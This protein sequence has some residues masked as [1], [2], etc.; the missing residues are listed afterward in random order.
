M[1][2]I[3]GRSLK[4]RIADGPLPLDEALSTARQIGDALSAAHAKGIIHRDIKPANIMLTAEGRPML[5][6]F[7]L[8]KVS[9]ATKLTRTGTTMGRWRTCRPSRCRGERPDHRS[10]IWALGV[11]LYE[12]VSGR[13]PFGGDYEAAMLYSILMRIPSHSREKVVTYL[14]ALTES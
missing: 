3:E 8:A 14:P 5:M 12:M 1:S 10:D 4:D 9:G 7:G 2:C 6:D 13:A 11:V